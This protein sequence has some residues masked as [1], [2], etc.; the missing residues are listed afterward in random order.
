MPAINNNNQNAVALSAAGKNVRRITMSTIHLISSLCPIC[1]ATHTAGRVDMA[2]QELKYYCPV[3]N[4]RHYGEPPRGNNELE[5]ECGSCKE[6]SDYVDW[7]KKPMD[8]GEI[9]CGELESCATCNAKLKKGNVALI[10]IN[11]GG[12]GEADRTGRVVFSKPK[13]KFKKTLGDR[14][15]VYIEK[16]ALKKMNG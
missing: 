4:A 10:E 7:E 1:S 6:S 13:G 16:T 12:S 8:A 3:C 5:Y 2:G 11:D 9:I 14:K 15:V